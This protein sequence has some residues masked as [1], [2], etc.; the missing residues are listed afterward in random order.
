MQAG[1]R[2]LG[3]A[4]DGSVVLWQTGP[5]ELRTLSYFVATADAGTV[6][7]AAA[8]VHVTQPSLS[9][10]LRALE[11]DLGVDLFER[12][13]GK[14][15]LSQAGRTLLP[16]ARGLLED[17]AALRRA[18]ALCADGVLTRITIAAP[19]TTLRDVIS[20]FLTT[21]ASTD[22]VP[23]VRETDGVQAQDDLRRGVD[24][25]LVAGRPVTALASRA[26]PA[27]PVWAYLPATHPWAG[28]WSIPLA[29][30][31]DEP[32][33]LLVG[34]HPSR[35]ALDAACV[36]AGLAVPDAIEA[37][38]GT[39]AQALCAAGRGVAVV[40]DDARFGLAR[41]V[42]DR[43]PVPVQ[44]LAVGEDQLL[45]HLHCVWDPRHPAADV[46][47]ELAERLHTFVVRRYGSDHG[48][49]GA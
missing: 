16:R 34:S 33:V 30:L 10:Q 12:T 3:G 23:S 2:P 37:T 38:D 39:V 7:A 35:R 28:R 43:R 21:M 31:M 44:R 14:V 20:P 29:E 19:A 25:A 11:R 36:A 32:L 24:L 47:A 15:S 27:L 4:L 49:V 41:A 46:L 42:I 45:V 18:A 48:M 9:R 6:S 22:P 1:G 8:R 17:A 40:S 26:L 5:V 13:P